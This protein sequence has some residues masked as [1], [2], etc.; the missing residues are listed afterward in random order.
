MN[1]QLSQMKG[2]DTDKS[3]GYLN[4]YEKIFSALCGSKV[5]LLELGIF[6]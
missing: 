2:Y 1:Q 4:N 5:Y 3:E 6:K